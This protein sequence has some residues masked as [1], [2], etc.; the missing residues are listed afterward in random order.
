MQH[1]QIY[2]WVDYR[3]ICRKAMLIYTTAVKRDITDATNLYQIPKY[4]EPKTIMTQF[5]SN[6]SSQI[7]TTTLVN[8]VPMLDLFH[9]SCIVVTYKYLD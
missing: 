9:Q 4:N 7:M 2:K 3:Q 6:G 1:K 5:Q 8:T